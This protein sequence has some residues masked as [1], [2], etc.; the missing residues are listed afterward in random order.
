MTNP[1]AY[2]LDDQTAIYKVIRERRDMQHFL[3][4]P[5]DSTLLQKILAAAHHAPSI[6]LMQLWRFI[7][8]TDLKIRQAIHKK[9]DAERVK[10]RM[11]LANVKH[12]RVCQNFY[13]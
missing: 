1:H 11:R 10:K 7:R 4:T 9:V 5:V 8:I 12:P 6:G 3:P 2:S 13:V